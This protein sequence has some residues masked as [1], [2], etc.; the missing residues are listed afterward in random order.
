MTNSVLSRSIGLKGPVIPAEKVLTKSTII[1]ASPL[2][3]C[4]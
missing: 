1:L 2:L 4:F 3:C